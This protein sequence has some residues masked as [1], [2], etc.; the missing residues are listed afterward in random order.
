MCTYTF[1]CYKPIVSNFKFFGKLLEYIILISMT[2][3]Y[4]CKKKDAVKLICKAFVFC[5]YFPCS[6]LSKLRFPSNID[7]ISRVTIQIPLQ[8]AAPSRIRGKPDN[9]PPPRDFYKF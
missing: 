4:N 3:M 6:A 2:K 7:C 8:Q 1:K 9:F 5:S